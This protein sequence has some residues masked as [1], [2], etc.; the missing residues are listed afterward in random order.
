[1]AVAVGID[2]AKELHW[3]EWK[4]AETGQVLGSRGVENTP[5]DI[6]AFIDQIELA[7]AEHGPATVGVDVLGG[8]AGLVVAMLAASD[9]EVVHTPGLLVNRTRQGTVGG[10]R[11]SD[12]K[13]ARVIADLVRHRRDLRPVK[14]PSEA[15]A[16]LRLL[17]ARRKDIVA[18]QTRRLTRMRD[19]L[20]AHHPG[21]ERVVDVTGKAGLHLLARYVTP[22]EIRAAGPARIRRYMAT[23][24]HLRT[25]VIDDLVDAAVAAAKA[26]HVAISGQSVA[27]DIVRD[28]AREA[29]E[30]RSR[31]T[32][33]DRRIEQAVADH[34]DGALV[35]SLPG[36]GATLTA[37]LLAEIGGI[38]RFANG[39]QLASAAGLAP[40]LRQSGKMRYTQRPPRRQQGPQ[41]RLLPIRVL[42]HPARSCLSC[43]LRPQ[44]RRGQ[45]TPPGADRSRAPTSQ[46]PLRPAPH[47]HALHRTRHPERARGSVR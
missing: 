41:T 42:R 34:P 13:D 23:A 30:V 11:K 46:C 45:T 38:G 26:Q 14:M 19:L 8:I 10:E 2:V 44:A 36:M 6:A 22:P 40:V 20:T 24:G 16:A 35:R 43:L 17:V 7:T 1:M 32:D 9:V 33:L 29:L 27:A 25:S 3:A 31:L 21:L 15:D 5:Q 12:P 28:L 39:D 37:E 4:V 47:T 18:D